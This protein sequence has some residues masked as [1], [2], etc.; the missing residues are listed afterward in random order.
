MNRMVI[1]HID[2]F[3]REHDVTYERIGSETWR[4]T[5]EF[6]ESIISDARLLFEIAKV[7]T[8]RSQ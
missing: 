5:S 8:E 7:I 4:A 2:S 3:G 1:T 6:G